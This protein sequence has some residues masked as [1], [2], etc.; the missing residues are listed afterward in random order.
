MRE[1]KRGDGR[2]VS[3]RTLTVYA[4]AQVRRTLVRYFI[5]EQC[6]CADQRTFFSR[7][8]FPFFRSF[9]RP[10]HFAASCDFFARSDGNFL[11]TLNLALDSKKI[12]NDILL[13]LGNDA[14]GRNFAAFS[15]HR[16]LCNVKMTATFSF[17]SEYF[18]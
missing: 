5:S 16:G 6:Q 9:S 14:G 3:E 13:R 1:I 8:Y 17:P 2:N 10:L 11:M 18:N 7:S 15:I 4:H 12:V